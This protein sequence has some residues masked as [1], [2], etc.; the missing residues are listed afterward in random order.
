MS[1][2]EQNRSRML[3][4]ENVLQAKGPAHRKHTLFQSRG[5]KRAMGFQKASNELHMAL[6]E[7]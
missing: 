3:K 1:K 4:N 2:T 5:A 7:T 6:P